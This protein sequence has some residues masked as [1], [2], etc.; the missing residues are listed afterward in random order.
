M[1]KQQPKPE[2]ML[3]LTVDGQPVPLVPFVE[4]II[5]DAVR[6]MVRTLHGCE[7]ADYIE[8]EIRPTSLSE[9]TEL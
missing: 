4:R 3:D 2:S 1:K 8:L 7:D 5:A 9:N 6:A